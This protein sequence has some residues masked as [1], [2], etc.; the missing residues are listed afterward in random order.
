MKMPTIYSI[1]QIMFSEGTIS[2]SPEANIKERNNRTNKTVIGVIFVIT[3][4]WNFI[5][6]R[7]FDF[8]FP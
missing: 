6:E 5:S 8:F 4:V 2:M 7:T 3:F 1:T